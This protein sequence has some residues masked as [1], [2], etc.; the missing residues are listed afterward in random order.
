M[1]LKNAKQAINSQ[2]SKSQMANN[3]QYLKFKYPNFII[4]TKSDFNH[5]FEI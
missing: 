4:F 5:L 3:S 2:Y 1:V